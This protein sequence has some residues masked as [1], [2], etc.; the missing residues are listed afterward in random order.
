MLY[1]S[2]VVVELPWGC[3]QVRWRL[4]GVRR[5]RE[6]EREARRRRRRRRR[7]RDGGVLH[8]RW[9]EGEAK[10]RPR[11]VAQSVQLVRWSL[12]D[13]E[14]AYYDVHRIE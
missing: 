6:A 1:E 11:E 2:D 12:S 9:G 8:H 3:G 10:L 7:G 4:R 13:G 5:R 14:V